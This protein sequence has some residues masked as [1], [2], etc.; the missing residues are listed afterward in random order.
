M[1]NSPILYTEDN[2]R[3][4]LSDLKT[5]TRR[6]IRLPAAKG[7]NWNSV[8]HFEFGGRLWHPALGGALMDGPSLRCPY[9]IVGDRLWVRETWMQLY[10]ADGFLTCLVPTGQQQQEVLRRAKYRATDKPPEN[11]AARWKPNIH[12]PRWASRITLEVTEVRVQRVQQISEVDATAEGCI[13]GYGLRGGKSPVSS[14]WS[15]KQR[16]SFLW[17]QINSKRGFSWQS[18]PW[19]WCITFKKLKEEK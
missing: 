9:G 15:A 12:M 5:Q 18:N 4:L 17:D 19:V 2:V 14:M 10:Q 11:F 16:F 1:K 7:F 6:C 3:K 13:A 8:D